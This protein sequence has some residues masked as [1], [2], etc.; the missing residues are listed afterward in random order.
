MEYNNAC[1]KCGSIEKKQGKISGIASLH[2]L[3]S[4]TGLGGSELIVEF[5]N[6]CGEVTSIKVKNPSAIK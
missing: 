3:D 6:D 4:K 1:N 2:S 5:C